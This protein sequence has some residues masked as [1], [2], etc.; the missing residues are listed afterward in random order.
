MV[1]TRSMLI[2]SKSRSVAK[3]MA[4]ARGPSPKKRV[5]AADLPLSVRTRS[6]LATAAATPVAVRPLTV[7]TR[8]ML[9]A[10][11][12]TQVQTAAIREP[13]ELRP[14]RQ[15]IIVTIPL[16]PYFLRPRITFA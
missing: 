10:A 16:T 9:A 11:A 6:M 13:Y 12:A 8:S 7:R 1:Q 14:R 4:V 15:R 5:P 3:K 2:A